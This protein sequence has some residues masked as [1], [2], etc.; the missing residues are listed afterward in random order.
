LVVVLVGDGVGPAELVLVG[1]LHGEVVA[2]SRRLLLLLA[3]D[4]VR[5]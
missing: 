1:L 5:V 3:D 2:I 4:V